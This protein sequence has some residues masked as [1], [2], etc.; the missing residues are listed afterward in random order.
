MKVRTSIKKGISSPIIK[1]ISKM[2]WTMD[3]AGI[4]KDT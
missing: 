4:R 3:T 1:T 2:T